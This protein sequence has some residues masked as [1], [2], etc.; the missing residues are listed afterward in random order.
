MASLF[1]NF[2]FEMNGCVAICDEDKIVSTNKQNLVSSSVEGAKSLY[3]NE[4]K[5]G[6]NGIVHL[7]SKN[8]NWYG[9]QE[10]IMH[11]FFFRNI[12]YTLHAIQ[13]A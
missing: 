6:G 1:S 11:T 9:R 2:P 7:R 12:R 10:T 8:G 13:Y 4:F 5:S 3:E